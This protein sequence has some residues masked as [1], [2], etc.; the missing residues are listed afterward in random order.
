[1]CDVTTNNL[2]DGLVRPN[3]AVCLLYV[4]FL[5]ILNLENFQNSKQH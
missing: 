5:S 2:H 4:V 3:R 1:V